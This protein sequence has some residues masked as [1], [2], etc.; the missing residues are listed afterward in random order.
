MFHS[1]LL[2]FSVKQNIFPWLE[3]I[4]VCQS[5][6][7]FHHVPNENTYMGILP[8]LNSQPTLFM[9]RLLFKDHPLETVDIWV[10]DHP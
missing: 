4:T 7:A 9:S 5:A 3:R 8:E 6:G 1:M 2:M 10:T